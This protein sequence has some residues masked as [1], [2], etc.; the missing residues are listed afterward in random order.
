MELI[1]WVTRVVIAVRSSKKDFAGSAIEY[2]YYVIREIKKYPK[3]YDIYYG[4]ILEIIILID[5]GKLSE[6]EGSEQLDFLAQ[7]IDTE[8]HKII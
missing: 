3:I 4:G 1:D 8:I 6:D 2:A 5:D 7:E